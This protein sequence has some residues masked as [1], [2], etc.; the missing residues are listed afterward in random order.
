[1]EPHGGEDVGFLIKVFGSEDAQLVSC[2]VDAAGEPVTKTERLVVTAG[3]F[4]AADRS[5]KL[6]PQTTGLSSNR[7]SG[8]SVGGF[9]RNKGLKTARHAILFVNSR[10]SVA[11]L[12]SNA[13]TND[14]EV[15]P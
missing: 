10:L 2:T 14:Q 3:R 13:E 9:D 4:F 1:L 11:K 7:V 6:M 15:Q 12:F 5:P 8:L